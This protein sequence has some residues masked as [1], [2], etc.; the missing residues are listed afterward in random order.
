MRREIK[1]RKCETPIN[2]PGWALRVHGAM[3]CCSAHNPNPPGGHIRPCTVNPWL[4]YSGVANLL[5]SIRKGSHG[6]S[7]G[8]SRMSRAETPRPTLVMGGPRF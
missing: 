8:S 4:S 2:T 6:G 5:A 1:R 3:G 7:V